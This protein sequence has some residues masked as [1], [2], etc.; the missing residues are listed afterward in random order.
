MLKTGNPDKH[1][2]EER[3]TI[4]VNWAHRVSELS[5]RPSS[6]RNGRPFASYEQSAQLKTIFKIIKQSDLLIG[7][8]FI[9]NI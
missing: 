1:S 8:N 3:W 7:C 6:G 9:K 4:L 5:Q 2:G